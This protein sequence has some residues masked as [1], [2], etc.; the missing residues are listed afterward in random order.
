M[1]R[2]DR[3]DIEADVPSTAPLAELMD[4]CRTHQIRKN[5]RW[6]TF[7]LDHAGRPALWNDDIVDF[8]S[9]IELGGGW[10][11]REGAAGASW[12]WVT[13]R[14][15]VIIDSSPQPRLMNIEIEANPLVPDAVVQVSV[16][17]SATGELL[18]DTALS[19]VFRGPTTVQLAIAPASSVRHL[20]FS[21]RSSAE[22]DTLP[23][24]E[25]RDQM[26]YRIRRIYWD[27][28]KPRS[29]YA[30]VG[31]RAAADGNAWI[32]RGYADDAGIAVVTSSAYLRY[33][34]EYGPMTAPKACEM[35]FWITLR[36]SQ[37][38]VA[39]QALRGDRA[40]FLPTRNRFFK[41]GDDV[42]DCEI[43]I[44]VEPGEQFWFV[45]SNAREHENRSSRF[46]I[47]DFWGSV[48][49]ERL[50]SVADLDGNWWT[51]MKSCIK[52]WLGQP[53]NQSPP[54]DDNGSP[55]VDASVGAQP[56]SEPASTLAALES[57]RRFLIKFRPDN[58]HLNACG[59]FQLMSRTDWCELRGFAEFEMYSMNIDGLFGHTAYYAGIREHVFQWPACAY[60]IEH[61]S[62]SGWT[63]E[64]ED[65]LRKRIEERGIGWLD[66]TT[67][68]ML[69]S[70]MKSVNRPMIF[71]GPDWGFAQHQLPETVLTDVIVR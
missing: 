63:P 50:M 56:A 57:S 7:P 47:L 64:G 52:G 29:R 20:T 25:L 37:G 36:L 46:T 54:A 10:H 2:V 12:R 18:A 11:M 3:H 61:E 26:T 28:E 14:A 68:T 34:V 13:E 45:I 15:E 16:A 32:G 70:F 5:T 39:I 71:N 30:A 31:W 23:L 21:A 33:A 43:A 58:L 49:Q 51:R 67:V 69:A 42:Y 41:R 1:Y 6:G 55:S 35:H 22:R 24:Y 48:P 19:N 62:G 17:D 8:G 9:G 40:G 66:S 4:Y 65:K 44:D 59:D 38:T 53:A 27:S 60:H